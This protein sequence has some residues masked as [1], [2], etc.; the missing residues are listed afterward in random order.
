MEAPAYVLTTRYAPAHMP[1]RHAQRMHAAHMQQPQQ[2]L[3]IT[4]SHISDVPPHK[5]DYRASVCHS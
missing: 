4:T 3:T 5:G 2:S 1:A